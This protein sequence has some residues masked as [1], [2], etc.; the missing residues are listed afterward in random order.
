MQYQF[1]PRI[2][3]TIIETDTQY[4]MLYDMT[5]SFKHDEAFVTNCHY[6]FLSTFYM[7]I[8]LCHMYKTGKM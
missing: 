4:F 8:E 2:S 1:K 3:V 7:V 6:T 5:V